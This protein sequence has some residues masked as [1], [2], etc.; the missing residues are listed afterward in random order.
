MRAEEQPTL[1]RGLGLFSAFAVVAGSC[2]GSGVFLVASDVSRVVPAPLLALSVWLMAGLIS[3]MGGLVFAELGGMFPG[4]GGQYLYLR[5]AFGRLP[6]F[7]YGWT[8]FLVIQTGSIAGVA[9]SF[10]LFAA[11]LFPLGP[12]GLKL[13]PTAVIV[14][15]TAVNLLGVKKGAGVL[16]VLTGLK[17]LALATIALFGFAA[18]A[19]AGAGLSGSQG[20]RLAPYGVGLIAALWAFDGWNNLSFVAG[21][22]K[23][24][25]RNIPLALVGGVALVSALYLGV[26]YAFY[27]VLPVAAVS[28][29]A[30]PGADFARALGGEPAARALVAIVLVS[31]LGCLNGMVLCGPRVT[32]AVAQDGLLPRAVT[33]VH[34]RFRVPSVALVVQMVWAVILVWSGRYEQLFT[35]VVSAAFLFYG[36]TAAGL[37]VLR[38]RLPGAPRPYRVPLYPFLPIAYLLFTAAFV[39]NSVVEK[40]LES[41]AG[42][43]IVLL[44][45][46]AFF[47]LG[48][49]NRKLAAR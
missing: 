13:V 48:R 14:L 21:E 34:P 19:G 31:G 28:G 42:Y 12:L 18:P 23:E 49:R 11:G 20:F 26:N 29:S 9:A 8:L 38:A 40:P 1:V 37:L 46:P 7:L 17:V 39:V 43:G 41:L 44:G 10:A 6:A 45:V 47:L 35:L 33:W 27:R 25:R 22:V 24:P 16:D 15:F 2:I 3:L 4:T 36:L 30:F 32:F 5:E